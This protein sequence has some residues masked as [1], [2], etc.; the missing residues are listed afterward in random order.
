MTLSSTWQAIRALRAT[1]PGH[2]AQNSGRRRT[3]GAALQQ[4]EELAGAANAVG[5][6]A[7]PLP[8]FYSLSQAG[9][10]IAAAHLPDP[11]ELQS[12]GLSVKTGNRNPLHTAVLPTN[13][14]RNSFE[15]VS[16]SIGSP[17]LSGKVQLGALW[18]ANPDL[19]DVPIPN[20]AGNWPKAL[21]IP[22]GTQYLP[23][24][25]GIS[26]PNTTTLTTGGIVHLSAELQGHNG[27]EVAVAMQN[28]PS[29]DGAFP[30]FDGGSGND[31]AGPDQPVVRS[32]EPMGRSRT[33]IARSAPNEITFSD[34]W[35]RQRSFASIVEVDKSQPNL[36]HPSYKGYALPTVAG[37]ACPHPL[38]LWW[39]LL[40]GLSS[41][42]RYEPDVWTAAIDPDS[43][44]LAVSLERVLDVAA[45]QVPVRVLQGLRSI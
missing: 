24:T 7:K 13:Q 22:I 1:P 8:L 33:F 34:Y 29:F 44:E 17:L 11:W 12:H 9:R 23:A 20:G 45:E 21:D 2:A 3:F 37:G 28:Y 42:A 41:L 4:A 40:I 10:A 38:M 16:N 5:Y 19:S 26:D 14:S 15:G 30:I 39:T 18:A 6:A 27:K 43:S 31:P 25:A 36:V 35:E 32:V